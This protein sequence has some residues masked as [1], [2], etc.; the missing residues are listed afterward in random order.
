MKTA[1]FTR[2]EFLQS[3]AKLA[4]GLALGSRYGFAAD[5]AKTFKGRADA[6]IMIYLPGGVAQQDTWDPKAHTPFAAGMK[7]SDLL[8]T[9]RTIRT[10]AD[11]IS[12]GEGLEQIATFMDH[13]A[14]IRSLQTSARFGASHVKA[15]LLV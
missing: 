2:R 7:G 15:Q 10:V 12:L 6:V 8:S 14:L 13:G 1:S 11:P 4:A 3:G 5:G 9:C